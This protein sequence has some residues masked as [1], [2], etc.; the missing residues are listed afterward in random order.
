MRLTRTEVL[1][2]LAIQ[3][4]DAFKFYS[5]MLWI[6]CYSIKCRLFLLIPLGTEIV[7]IT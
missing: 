1:P 2:G 7:P 5:N 4:D 6:V 3:V